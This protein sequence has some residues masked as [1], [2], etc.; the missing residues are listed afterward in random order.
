MTKSEYI[1]QIIYDRNILYGECP[2]EVM[3][4]YYEQDSDCTVIVIN[5]RIS[6]REK[7]AAKVH[8]LIHTEHPAGDLINAPADVIRIEEARVRRWEIEHL[9]P[10]KTLIDAFYLGYT[11]PLDLADFLE[12]TPEKLE[13]GFHLYYGIYGPR[14]IHGQYVVTWGPFDVKR[15]RRRKPVK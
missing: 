10:V 5:S 6:E 7:Y 4:G 3:R 2:L 9:M 11:R 8:E 12:I 15:D 1:D 14:S 13:E